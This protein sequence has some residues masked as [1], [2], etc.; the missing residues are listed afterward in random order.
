[1]LML[2][3][4]AA[5]AACFQGEDGD[6]SGVTD[7]HVRYWQYVEEG[8]ERTNPDLIVLTGD[9]IYGETDDEGELW[10]EMIEV[11]DSFEIP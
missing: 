10:L 2:A 11:L 7:T 8:G 4:L 5:L 6:A 9:N 3:C 1:M